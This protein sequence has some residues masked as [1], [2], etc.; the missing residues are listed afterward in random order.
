[1]LFPTSLVGSYPQPDW[2]IDREKL[3]GPVPAAGPGRRAV[4]GG[5]RATWSRPSRTPPCW[6][7]GHRRRRAW[8]SSPTARSAGRATPTGSRP[9]WTAWTSTTR[10]PRWTAAG[11]RTRCPGSS[12]RSAR[13][14]PVA[15]RRPDV[16]ARAHRPDGQDDRA[17]AVHHGPAGAERLLP[18]PRGGGVRLRRGGQR[19][20]Q[21]PVRGR[22]PTSC[23][24]TS[25]TCRPAP[26]EARGYGVAARE[27][28]ARGRD[29]HHRRASLLRL[30]GD[31]PRAPVGLLVP[32][33]ARGEHAP[34]RCRSRPRSP[35]WTAPCSPPWTARRS[36]WACST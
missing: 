5:P 25:R 12:G 36:S 2:L 35:G 17:R 9:R 7:S 28:G 15:G 6:R 34:T 29:R 4:A 11:T 1:M 18:E 22:A 32:A 10:A 31:H 21:G 20:G 19:G 3:A 24:S 14:H 8:T 23:S 27:P 16:P 26:D 30:R 33:R 13:R